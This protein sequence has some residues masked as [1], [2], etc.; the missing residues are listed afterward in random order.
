MSDEPRVEPR[1]VDHVK[2]LRRLVCG[3]DI[4]LPREEPWLI[5]GDQQHAP[6][7]VG[8]VCPKRGNESRFDYRATPSQPETEK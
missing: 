4:E 6:T 5:H 7:L 1:A 3:S 8:F 2:I